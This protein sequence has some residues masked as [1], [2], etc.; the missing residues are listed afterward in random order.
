M[1]WSDRVTVVEPPETVAAIA[2]APRQAIAG[3]LCL[4]GAR[5]LPAGRLGSGFLVCREAA[6][7]SGAVKALAGASWDGRFRRPRDQPGLP[8]ETIGPLGAESRRFRRMSD[9]PAVVL[10]TLPAY[11]TFDGDLIAVPGLTWP[12][13]RVVSTRQLLFH[14]PRPAAGGTFHGPIVPKWQSCHDGSG[15]RP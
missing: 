10:E 7:M 15:S 6:A 11:H 9:L 13:A 12:D 8:R 14:P 5:L 1:V 4:G 3:G 2:S